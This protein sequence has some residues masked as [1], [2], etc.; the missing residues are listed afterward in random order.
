M[1]AQLTE[2]QWL[3]A[4][5][6]VPLP[7]LAELSGLSITELHVLTEHGVFLPL[8]TTTKE[9]VYSADCIVTARI[10]CRLRDDLDMDIEALGLVLNLLGRVHELEA[11]I[12]ELEALLPRI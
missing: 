6:D 1:K 7:T 8:D 4:H 9:P 11:R 10:A 12:R 3:D 5:E 2:V